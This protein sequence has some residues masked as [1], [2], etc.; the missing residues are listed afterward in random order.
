MTTLAD[1]PA[2]LRPFRVFS[3]ALA[4]G[5][6]LA[7][8]EVVIRGVA[9]ESN[10]K[11][12][13]LALAAFTNLALIG[14]AT[15]A[16]IVLAVSL[17]WVMSLALKQHRY[18]IQSGLL[19][20]LTGL[21]AGYATYATGAFGLLD[22]VTVRWA[23]MTAA[24]G[25]G[26]II[27]FGVW[28]RGISLKPSMMNLTRFGVIIA[29][30]GCMAAAGAGFYHTR[31]FVAEWTT[32]PASAENATGNHASPNMLLVILDTLRAD[33]VGVY[34]DSTLTPNIDK[35]AASSM[36]YS[37][38]ISTA[39][40]TLPSH[41]SFL[42][43]LY[44]EAHGVNWGHY[45]LGDGVPVLPDLLKKKGYQTFAVSNNRL[46]NEA[47]GFGRGFDRFVETTNDACLGQWKLALRC[48]AVQ[49]AALAMGLSRDAGFDQGS[50]WTNWL[51]SKRF[52][53]QN[54]E[55][56]PFF[57]MLNYYEPHDPYQAPRRHVDRFLTPE[58]RKRAGRLH[59][60]EEELARH[61][62]G[63]ERVF[64]P[65][66]VQ[67]LEKLYDADVAYQDE[68]LGELVALLQKNG[69]LNNTWLVVTSDHGELFGEWE[70]VYHTASSHY[71][72]LH[73]PLIVRPPGGTTEMV[74]I[75]APVQPV[76][77]FAT[78]LTTAGISLPDTV[79]QAYPL[80]LKTS[81]RSP[82]EMCV[83]QSHGA[84]IAGLSI[85]QRH[86]LQA[87]VSRW[88][89]WVNSVY[90]DGYLM[91]VESS[92]RRRLFN[93]D[94]DP[95]MK[96]DLAETRGEVLDSMAERFASWSA[97]AAAQRKGVTHAAQTHD[98]EGGDNA[99]SPSVARAGD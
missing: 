73:V 56:K 8:A 83:A 76:D 32:P 6:V 33:K 67:L 98:N 3:G 14:I 65:D 58:E 59:H 43:G 23:P 2:K 80:P 79:T 17:G 1:S 82:R 86:D 81:E 53:K 21:A 69:L 25:V 46:L 68:R 71:K 39:P 99:R 44:P 74:R 77:V 47:N 61:A 31:E 95:R 42:T 4:M 45:A 72:L 22:L 84:S 94:E 11:I 49:A 70:M 48:G 52:A 36:V 60:G 12:S 13:Q 19:V 97:V 34:G 91:E 55:R 10:L 92:G 41:A 5:F 20:T 85:T 29:W 27:A 62:C 89:Q 16:L 15:A 64:S 30:L 38:A 66:D 78:F 40:W 28:R 24:C 88:L 37:R 18:H 75:E 54:G 63:A 50:A 90:E 96:Q 7:I 51:L 35:L 57:A 93:V 87:D 26:G 9:F